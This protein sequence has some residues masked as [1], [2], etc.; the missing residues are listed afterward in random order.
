MLK[1]GQGL[2]GAAIASDGRGPLRG[3]GAEQ[4]RLPSIPFVGIAQLAAD[5]GHA[6]PCGACLLVPLTLCDLLLWV[7]DL[8]H[9]V[10]YSEG[11][12][13]FPT[14]SH[15]II[16]RLQTFLSSF[17]GI[18]VGSLSA[19]TKPETFPARPD[20]AFPL[21]SHQTSPFPFLAPL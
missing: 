1:L 9:V 19:A 12:P 11:N 7:L 2:R 14:K 8:S 16:P 20:T 15:L 18:P 3:A 13:T 5:R 6:P 17:Q 4:E 10:S 21:P